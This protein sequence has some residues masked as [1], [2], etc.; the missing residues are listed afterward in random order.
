MMSGACLTG[1]NVLTALEGR[2]ETFRL[3]ALNSEPEEPA[4]YDFDHVL[5]VPELRKDPAR[6]TEIFDRAVEEL[7]PDL[8]IPCRDDDMLFLAEQSESSPMLRE[9]SLCGNADTAR[10]ML[11]KFAS[12]EFSRDHGLPFAPTIHSQ[13]EPS[14]IVAFARQH[15]LPVICKPEEGFA[16]KGVS[17]IMTESQLVQQIG[18]KGMVFQAYLGDPAIVANYVQRCETMGVP[19]FQSF[20][21]LK[22]SIQSYVRKD[23]SVGRIFVTENTM[24]QGRSELVR[25]TWSEDAFDIGTRCATAF[26]AS[27]WRGPLN[28]QCQRTPGGKLFIYEYNGRYTGATSA[29]LYLGYDEVGVAVQEYCGIAGFEATSGASAGYVRRALVSR[30]LNDGNVVELRENGVWNAK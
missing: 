27:G 10:A 22:I 14:A 28:I 8:I 15:R 17:I 25:E 11:N 5:L 13:D 1:Q 7:N 23:A 20:E 29:R 12:W 24:R 16:S 21:G 26:A 18:A 6:F 9:R 30:S 19:L 3:V 2:R 4:L